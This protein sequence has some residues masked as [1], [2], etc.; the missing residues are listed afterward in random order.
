MSINVTSVLQFMA[1]PWTIGIS[2]AS[3]H[4][5][6]EI[7]RQQL[8]RCLAARFADVKDEIIHSF[9]DLV[10]ECDDS[11]AFPLYDAA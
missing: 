8:T 10:P 2:I 6:L 9:E 5:H 3:R 11:N 1:I 4:Y 7:I